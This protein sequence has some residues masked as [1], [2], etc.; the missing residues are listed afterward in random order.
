LVISYLVKNLNNKLK[1]C[2]LFCLFLNNQVTKLLIPSSKIAL[3][4]FARAHPGD[5]RV[6]ATFRLRINAGLI[7][8][9]MVKDQRKCH[10]EEQDPSSVIASEAKQ[11][12]ACL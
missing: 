11:S 7:L 5:E 6:A 2:F 8:A 10:C 4:N 1:M 9:R 3:G 12:H